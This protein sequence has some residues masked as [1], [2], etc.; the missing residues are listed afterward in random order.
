MGGIVKKTQ[1]STGQFDDIYV[2]PLDGYFIIYSPLRDISAIC[3]KITVQYLYDILFGNNP[4]S[5][6]QT[7]LGYLLKHISETSPHYPEDPSDI[8]DPYFLGIIPTRTCNCNCIYCDFDSGRKSS[9]KMNYHTA[10]TA[11][12]WMAGRMKELK[13]ERLEIHFFGGEPLFAPD[14]VNTAVHYAKTAA[15]EKGLIPL[16]EVSTNGLVPDEVTRFVIEHFNSVVLSLDGPEEIHNLQRPMRKPGNSFK[17]AVRFAERVSKSDS[18][19]CL[20]ACISS[21]NVDRMPEITEW[22]C[23]NFNPS[24]IDFENLKSNQLS[25]RMGIYEPDPCRFAIQFNKSLSLAEK[26]GVELVNSAIVSDQPQYSSCPVGKDTIIVSP[27]GVLYSCY[28]IPERW[29]EKNMDLSVGELK[30]GKIRISRERIM[31]LRKIVKEK[32]RCTSCFC[33]WTCA[34]GCH[35]D[36]TF[37]GSE[38][39]YD[40]YCIQTRILGIIKLLRSLNQQEMLENIL[41]DDQK[42][43]RIYMLTSD[44]LQD[45]RGYE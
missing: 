10:V 45:W 5:D 17:S 14:V 11:I 15:D 12:E 16:F 36:V 29:K 1:R 28:L 4:D 33:R 21:V 7:A 38:L 37:P 43:K 3:D 20:R 40:N 27:D 24:T 42:L 32:P 13:K 35:V 41:I 30:D 18:R 34:G 44:K 39:K 26:Y 25:E 2:L 31:Y 9:K 22:F 8:P 19:L 6:K 23:D